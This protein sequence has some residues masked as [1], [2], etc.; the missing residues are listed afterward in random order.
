MPIGAGGATLRI[1]GIFALSWLIVG[2]GIVDPI[3]HR[4]RVPD[5]AYDRGVFLV[6]T[7][8]VAS[9]PMMLRSVTP[10]SDRSD[11]G[12]GTVDRMA[13]ETGRSHRRGWTVD[14]GDSGQRQQHRNCQRAQ[15][16]DRS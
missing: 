15:Q 2:D 5:R 11:A 16:R 12:A 1:G 9:S 13:S 6:A 3:R 14:L 7:L 8:I 4:N 10:R